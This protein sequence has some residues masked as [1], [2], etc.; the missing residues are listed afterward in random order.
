MRILSE[1]MKI[2]FYQTAADLDPGETSDNPEKSLENFVELLSA[3][4]REKYPDAVFEHQKQSNYCEFSL[5]GVSDG[6]EYAKIWN[7]ASGKSAE[8]Y[9][10]GDFWGLK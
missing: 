5:E 6:H 4:I 8:I 1:T 10:K 9:E 3:A 7:F 2:T